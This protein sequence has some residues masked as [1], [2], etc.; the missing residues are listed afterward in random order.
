[1]FLSNL[2][3]LLQYK[4]NVVILKDLYNWA[5]ER[6]FKRDRGLQIISPAMLGHVPTVLRRVRS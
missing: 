3:L 5:I 4:K 2:A 1:M 6:A